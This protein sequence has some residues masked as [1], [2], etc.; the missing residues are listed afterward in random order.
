MRISRSTL[1]FVVLLVVAASTM[2]V[3][4]DSERASKVALDPGAGVAV[5]GGEKFTLTA[6]VTD[7]DGSNVQPGAVVMFSTTTMGLS[8]TPTSALT[9]EHGRATSVIIV[10]YGSSAVCQASTSSG[11]IDVKVAQ[12][13]RIK[14]S[15]DP[16]AGAA[17]TGGEEFTLTAT[18]TDDI[19]TALEAGTVVAFATTTTGLSVTPTSAVTDAAGK[20]YA[21]I[22]VPYGSA[23]VCQASTNGGALDVKVAQADRIKV[24]ATVTNITQVLDGE[25]IEL[26]GNAQTLGS[27]NLVGVPLTFTSSASGIT[28]TPPSA[29]T[30]DNGNA[31]AVAFVPFTSPGVVGVVV[32]GGAGSS[33]ALSPSADR[34][35]LTRS[36]LTPTAEV[37]GTLV[38]LSIK[39]AQTVSLNGSDTDEA[40]EGITASFSTSGAQAFSPSSATTNVSGIATSQAFIPYGGPTLAIVSVAGGSQ[41]FPLADA[42]PTILIG[43]LTVGSGSNASQGSATTGKIYPVSVTVTNGADSGNPGLAGV[44]LAFSATGGAQFNPATVTTDGSGNAS[45]V[46]FVPDLN[47]GSASVQI[48]ATAPGATPAARTVP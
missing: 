18:I 9:D 38:T 42:L 13:D 12:A 6:T 43:A 48:A 5:E 24:A 44:P 30:D 39:V 19:G 35:K 32:G 21:A 15:L 37:G 7:E 25:M 28:F 47:S 4:C 33:T 31:K 20:A 3:T 41:V 34:I 16:G 29:A 23:A 1:R 40:L 46:V 17:V 36:S 14:V 11:A 10:P 26:T 22:V 45:T 2:G 27:S 8:V